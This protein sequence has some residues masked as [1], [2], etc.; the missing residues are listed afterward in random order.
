MS[1]DCNRI[2]GRQT[3]IWL[4]DCA[5]REFF[6]VGLHCA[7]LD[8]NLNLNLNLNLKVFRC[9]RVAVQDSEMT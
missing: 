1:G 9:V 5:Y 2:S 8:L 6:S 3:R 7:D 4:W